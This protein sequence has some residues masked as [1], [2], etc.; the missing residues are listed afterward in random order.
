MTTTAVPTSTFTG[1]L[2]QSCSVVE[3]NGEEQ[4]PSSATKAGY[5]I[6]GYTLY[7]DESNPGMA[8]TKAKVSGQ[9]LSQLL[10]RSVDWYEQKLE[11]NPIRTKALT[12][13]VLGVLGDL[14]AQGIEL[15]FDDIGGEESSGEAQSGL[16]CRRVV[17]M[18]LDG[19][20]FCGPLMHYAYE[21]YE[22]Y[23][24]LV[25][26]ECYCDDSIAHFDLSMLDENDGRAVVKVAN[27]KTDWKNVLIHVAFDQVFM[28]M[29][30]LLGL[31]VITSVVE[32]HAS[33][34]GAE[35]QNYYV[36]NLCTSWLAG[37]LF[38]APMQILAFGKL[39]KEFRVLATNVIDM[40]WVTLMS[41][42]THLHRDHSDSFIK[43]VLIPMLATIGGNIVDSTR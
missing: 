1:D 28:M 26:S 9:Q 34:L 8:T 6:D 3:I 27:F 10:T 2:Q 12:A 42:V 11:T 5:A 4:Q 18:F 43:T 32:G 19:F 24:P 13:G 39:N 16:D 29:F 30:Y 38:F 41:I 35:L 17:A 14:L 33:D 23:F 21:A 25:R 31:M 22:H 20:C 15:S 37:G 40:F 36:R 7:H